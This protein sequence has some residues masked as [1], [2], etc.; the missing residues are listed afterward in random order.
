MRKNAALVLGAMESDDLVRV[1]LNAYKKEDTLFVKSAYLKALLDLDY[2]EELPY[3][4]ERLQELDQEPVTEANQKHIREEA[5]MLQ[6]LISQKEKRKKH[7]FDGFDRQVE[8]ILLTNREQREATRNQLKEEKVTMLAGGMRFFTCDLEAIL[9]ILDLERTAL[10]GKRAENR[11]RN[12]GKRGFTAGSTGAGTVEKP[13]YRRRCL[14]LPHR[15]EESDVSGE[16]GL[17]GKSIF[18]STGESFRKR[19]GQFHFGL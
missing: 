6:Q 12:T 14:L 18:C 7:T 3:L 13:S 11:Q 4:K 19:T 8:V 2:E 16:K 15:A 5:G 1:L 10:S 17:L 9:P